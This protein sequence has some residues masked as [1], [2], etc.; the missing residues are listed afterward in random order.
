MT[1]KML[2]EL[3]IL[4]GG[5]ET[6]AGCHVATL[7]YLLPRNA[8]VFL[9]LPLS[10]SPRPTSRLS[11]VL[12][13]GIE[14]SHDYFVVFCCDLPQVKF[15]K[16]SSL[17]ERKNTASIQSGGIQSFCHVVKSMDHET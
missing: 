5:I 13:S 10:F 8:S 11:S 7:S 14:S 9:Y 3:L 15:S 17:N 1:E 6:C 2:S 4:S 12:T 16:G